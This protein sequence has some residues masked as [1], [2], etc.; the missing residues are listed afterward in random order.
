LGSIFQNTD[1]LVFQNTTVISWFGI[2]E[3]E[4][5]ETI[6]E[7]SIR[8]FYFELSDTWLS[9]TETPVEIPI[10][11]FQ[12]RKKNVD[13]T[14]LSVVISTDEHDA[15]IA[16]MAESAV[17]MYLYIAYELWGEIYY[18]TRIA[19]V[20]L[21][22][23]QTHDGS[24]SRSVTLTGYKSNAKV[25]VNRTITL[26]YSYKASSSGKVRYRFADLDLSVESGDI[27]TI[28]GTTFTLGTISIT[29]S[30]SYF[31]IEISEA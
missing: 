28:D 18:K 30:D 27:V 12:L 4:Y 19:N 31:N 26:P 7:L 9:D 6:K 25:P 15:T 11:S 16:E 17:A 23:I 21:N 5:D 13:E 8:R 22:D 20:W 2:Q 29:C 10:S 3:I 1:T 24:A 14:Y